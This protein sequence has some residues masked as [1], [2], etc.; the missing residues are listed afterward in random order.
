MFCR[1]C[2]KEVQDT[3]RF[4][5]SCGAPLQEAPAAVTQAPKKE[6]PTEVLKEQPPVTVYTSAE[7]NG[8]ES[9]YVPPTQSAPS[10][11]VP[12]EKKAES[13]PVILTPNYRA[14]EGSA[15]APSEEEK[16][17]LAGEILKFGVMSLAF[18]CTLILAL[19]GIIFGIV[20]KNKVNTYTELFGPVAWRAK[21]GRSIGKAGLIAGIVGTAYMAL[22]CSILFIS[23]L[24]I[25]IG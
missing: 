7:S 6:E 19:F 16:D 21:V 14:P 2:G 25:L 18:S 15:F 3:D 22:Y 24:P 23:I 12:T 17:N 10:Y 20:T 4:C 1:Y 8:A 13:E 11:Y 9:F 5:A